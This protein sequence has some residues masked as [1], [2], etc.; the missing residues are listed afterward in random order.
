MFA[1]NLLATIS[2]D[3]PFPVDL[4]DGAEKNYREYLYRRLC[5]TPFDCGRYLVMPPFQKSE[6]SI[7]LYSLRDKTGAI[8]YYATCLEAADSLRDW[9]EGGKFLDRANNV[10]IRRIDRELPA[11]TCSLMKEVWMKMLSGHSRNSGTPNNFVQLDATM[12][13]FAIKLRSGKVFRGET[14]LVPDLGKKMTAFMQIGDGLIDYCK[15]DDAKRPALLG[16]VE[17]GAKSLLARLNKSR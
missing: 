1:S 16:K 4:P 14:Q 12:G 10:K 7:S 6:I 5:S 11:T 2:P 8:K 3:H 9:S 13:E 15:A 17:L